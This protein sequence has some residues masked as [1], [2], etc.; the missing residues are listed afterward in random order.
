M[1]RSA[2]SSGSVQA[3][4]PSPSGPRL[5]QR[6]ATAT[7]P[8]DIRLSGRSTRRG[9]S[10]VSHPP[11]PSTSTLLTAHRVTQQLARSFAPPRDG[12][13][14]RDRY[15]H[16]AQDHLAADETPSE[17]AG[18]SYGTGT[19]RG[20]RPQRK[21]NCVYFRQL[22]VEVWR[23]PYSP[24]D[25]CKQQCDREKGPRCRDNNDP[26]RMTAASCYKNRLMYN[27]DRVI[28]QHDS[29]DD[30]IPPACI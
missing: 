26:G 20:Q 14:H 23:C 6:R 29:I 10:P 11:N 1:T 28:S 27:G 13:R 19:G 18:G 7:V 17:T 2:R 9:C 30:A 24:V 8:H 5:R 15:K 21:I 25:N 12:D 16:K 4:T 3:S 22:R